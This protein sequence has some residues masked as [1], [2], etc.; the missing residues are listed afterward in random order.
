[1]IRESLFQAIV[2]TCTKTFSLLSHKKGNGRILVLTPTAS[3]SLGDEA[4]VRATVEELHARTITSRI[5]LLIWSPSDRETF[6]DL[7]VD[8]TEIGKFASAPFRVRGTRSIIFWQLPRLLKRL[9]DASHLFILGADVLDGKY[10]ERRSVRRLLVAKMGAIIGTKTS[11]IG[12]SYSD[13]AT[14]KTRKSMKSLPHSVRLSCRDPHSQKRVRLL[15]GRPVQGT[16][17]LAFLLKPRQANDEDF[18]GCVD[19]IQGC[20]ASGRK[21]IGININRQAFGQSI[22]E[23][24]DQAVTAYE[25]LCEGLQCIRMPHSYCCHMITAAHTLMQHC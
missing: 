5:C 2:L 9:S 7:D 22:E 10:S 18:R 23:D 3:G 17:D 19:A 11:I 14:S 21:I 8:F 20:R 15:C 6:A 13:K 25:N 16:A 24:P 4:M 1:M 12:F